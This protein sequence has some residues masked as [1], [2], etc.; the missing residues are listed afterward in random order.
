VFLEHLLPSQ[1]SVACT[2]H[3]SLEGDVLIH[4]VFPPRDVKVRKLRE[5]VRCQEKAMHPNVVRVYGAGISLPTEEG[6]NY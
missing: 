1:S 3:S 2:A 5:E 4:Q 6:T